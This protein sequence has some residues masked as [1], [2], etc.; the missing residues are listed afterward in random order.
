MLVHSC[1]PLVRSKGTEKWVGMLGALR[2]AAPVKL[3]HALEQSLPFSVKV[4]GTDPQL[5][6]SGAVSG[7]WLFVGEQVANPRAEDSSEQS[8][9]RNELAGSHL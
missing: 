2:F 6:G 8:S 5:F 3:T 7:H 4:T 9:L 1:T